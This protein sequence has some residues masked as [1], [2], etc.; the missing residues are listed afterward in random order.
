MVV[1]AAQLG[2]D[3]RQVPVGTA[4]HAQLDSAG[5]EG[6]S[7]AAEK[8]RCGGIKEQGQGVSDLYGRTLELQQHQGAGALQDVEVEQKRLLPVRG[9]MVSI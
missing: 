8:E 7:A 5:G 9:Q 4:L 6:G 3:Q 2:F 1:P